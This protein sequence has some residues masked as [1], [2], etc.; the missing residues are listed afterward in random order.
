MKFWARQ[1]QR[2]LLKNL[3][4]RLVV[5]MVVTVIVIHSPFQAA[6]IHGLRV[7]CHISAIASN[8]THHSHVIIHEKN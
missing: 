6:E 5:V 7:F 4:Q 1:R 3:W 8:W 2:A